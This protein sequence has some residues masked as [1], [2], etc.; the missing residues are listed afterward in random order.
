MAQPFAENNLGSSATSLSHAGVIGSSAPIRAS[1]SVTV[2]EG[3]TTAKPSPQQVPHLSSSSDSGGA[4]VMVSSSLRYTDANSCEEVFPMHTLQEATTDVAV[5]VPIDHTRRVCVSDVD[6]R[7]TKA[8]V[9]Q[10]AASPEV[11]GVAPLL[12]SKL[13]KES[14]HSSEPADAISSLSYDT[15]RRV[16]PRGFI[17]GP[18]SSRR[19]SSDSSIVTMTSLSSPTLCTSS[20]NSSAS[21]SRTSS[22]MYNSS[23]FYNDGR[24]RSLET[25]AAVAKSRAAISSSISCLHAFSKMPPRARPASSARSRAEHFTELTKP[26]EEPLQGESSQHSLP[27]DN[28][29]GDVSCTF[30]AAAPGQEKLEF[31]PPPALASEE[32]DPLPSP[33]TL[34]TVP[35]TAP[36]ITTVPVTNQGLNASGGAVP[37][38]PVIRLSGVRS[39]PVSDVE[40]SLVSIPALGYGPRSTPNACSITSARSGRSSR[41]ARH[42]N[43]YTTTLRNSI[44]NLKELFPSLPDELYVTR[45]RL[46]ISQEGKRQLGCGAYGT[47]QRAELYP[48]AADFPRFFTPTTDSLTSPTIS[49]APCFS[50]ANGCVSTHSFSFDTAALGSSG[51]VAGVSHGG[52]SGTEQAG[53]VESIAL[54]PDTSGYTRFVSASMLPLHQQPYNEQTASFY[55]GVDDMMGWRRAVERANDSLWWPESTPNDDATPDMATGQATALSVPSRSQ[56]APLCASVITGAFAAQY[57]TPPFSFSER[58]SNRKATAAISLGSKY[59]TESDLPLPVTSRLRSRPR[60]NSHLS[61][62][63]TTSPIFPVHVWECDYADATAVGDADNNTVHRG[64]CEKGTSCTMPVIPFFHTVPGEEEAVGGE[65]GTEHTMVASTGTHAFESLHTPVEGGCI[66]CRHGMLARHCVAGELDSRSDGSGAARA[67]PSYTSR[68]TTGDFIDT[69]SNPLVEGRA[70]SCCETAVPLLTTTV[71]L[72]CIGSR[73]TTLGST[74]FAE[75]FRAMDH[76]APSEEVTVAGSHPSDRG[77]VESDRGSSNT[78][79]DAYMEQDYHTDTQPAVV[80]PIKAIHIRPSAPLDTTGLGSTES[81]VPGER[82]KRR[83]DELA[84]RAAAALWSQDLEAGPGSLQVGLGV[85]RDS[86]QGSISCLKPQLLCDEAGCERSMLLAQ[87]VMWEVQEEHHHAMSQS[88]EE[89]EESLRDGLLVKRTGHDSP[90]AG[91]KAHDNTRYGGDAATKTAPRVQLEATGETGSV[92]QHL[93]PLSTRTLTSTP[94]SPSDPAT[95]ARVTNAASFPPRTHA[96]GGVGPSAIPGGSVA[97]SRALDSGTGSSAILTRDADAAS[98]R[99][100]TSTMKPANLGVTLVSGDT[101]NPLRLSSDFPRTPIVRRG[102]SSLLAAG[103]P[104]DGAARFRSVAIKVVEKADLICNSLK[105]NAFHNELR[106][107]SRLHHP[108]LVKTFGVAEDAD[109]FYLVMDL[110]EKGNLA[111]YQQKFGVAHTREMAPRFMADIVCALEYLGDGSQHSYL[112][113]PHPN[114]AGDS[115]LHSHSSSASGTTGIGDDGRVA[116]ALQPQNLPDSASTHSLHQAHEGAVA[117]TVSKQLPMQASMALSLSSQLAGECA[118]DFGAG[119]CSSISAMELIRQESKRGPSLWPSRISSTA[120]GYEPQACAHAAAIQQQQ[121]G[122]DARDPRQQDSVIVHRDLKPE[123]LLLTCNLHVKLADFG[124]AC[125]YGDDEANGFGGTPSYISPEVLTRCKASPYSDLWALGCV[126]YELLV[127]ERLFSGSLADV[128]DA[129]RRFKP[130]AL[131][132]PELLSPTPTNL[133]TSTENRAQAGGIGAGAGISEAAKD[134]VRQLLQ[135]VPEERIGSV[136]RGGFNVLKAHPFFAE[137]RWDRL[138]QTTSIATTNAHHM[139]ALAE[140]LGPAEVVVHCSP[141]KVWPTLEGSSSEGYLS[142]NNSSTKFCGSQEIL[143]MVLTDAPRLFLVDPDFSS[144]HL[145]IPWH[146][147]LRVCVLCAEHLTITVPIS[148][149]LNSLSTPPPETLSVTTTAGTSPIGP[150]NNLGAVKGRMIT[151]TF[152]DLERRAALWGA[153]IDHLPSVGPIKPEVCGVAGASTP[154]LYSAPV[155]PMTGGS[156]HLLWFN[157]FHHNQQQHCRGTPILSPRAGICLLHRLR[158][159]RAMRSGSSGNVLTLRNQHTLCTP[160]DMQDAAASGNC[161]ELS[162]YAYGSALSEFITPPAPP[163]HLRTSSS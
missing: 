141:V 62:S 17:T 24:C 64:R 132:F 144:I 147:G 36:P 32:R 70:A 137:I 125:F 101:T 22:L 33:D 157:D 109:N 151:Y 145:E 53:R 7:S 83:R 135:P 57:K 72:H 81:A 153:K 91:Q 31:L 40:R 35:R 160:R 77:L 47:V 84:G 112:M 158:T 75:D 46:C 150:R 103:M 28:R 19:T 29:N 102:V 63:S 2:L 155:A 68:I 118:D 73:S 93:T 55:N 15:S 146:A 121:Q 1:A 20:L 113:A 13:S 10:P 34:V 78:L 138:L 115:V 11:M 8:L 51:N 140:Y 80:A 116:A 136:E 127:G 74:E 95:T 45:D 71:D 76:T 163:S 16:S 82:D 134:L 129:L 42:S 26:P 50:P 37:N 92:T 60:S 98:P 43:R 96:P 89:T 152:S 162:T 66:Y 149:T 94:A 38:V 99:S 56:V 39:L 6:S 44:P 143:L 79:P 49:S 100:A 12:T 114:S 23:P 119:V 117:A 108:C 86:S 111:Q 9:P 5:R 3:A 106:M 58:S 105:L 67:S 131:E 133:S 128:G 104:T 126:L 122:W 14:L 148:D 69:A 142:N 30:E 88:P 110:A 123:N 59:E 48:P 85:G 4:M 156:S 161:A 90:S 107:A 130:E 87:K 27:S 21:H 159:T 18:C 54:V 25:E 124:D 61:F 120:V 41:S 97:S 65:A 154:C 52:H 139:A